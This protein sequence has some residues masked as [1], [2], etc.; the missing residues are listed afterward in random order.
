MIVLIGGEKGGT[1]KS[2]LATNIAVW[3]AHEGQDVILV[4]ADNQATSKRWIDRRNDW[5]TEN[6]QKGEGRALLREVHVA[7]ANGDVYKPAID[8]AKRYQQVV[9]DAGGRDSKELRTAMVAADVILVP[10]RASQPDLETMDHV[11]DLIDL[12]RG[13]NPNLRAYAV[14]SMAPANPMINEAVEAQEFLQDFQ[15]L[16]LAA[17]FVRDRKVYRDAMLA[18]RGVIELNNSQA[19]AEIQLLGQAIYGGFAE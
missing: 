12:A 19:K 8:L 9:I 14:I 18:G 13:M 6:A 3:L 1:G 7:Q 17:T 10:T 16:E 15:Q 2:T 4:D 11:N 5:N